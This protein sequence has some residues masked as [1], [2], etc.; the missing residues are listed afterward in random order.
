MG[1]KSQVVSQTS[2]A[3]NSRETNAKL[4][5]IARAIAALA[6]FVDD[7]E[8]QLRRIESNQR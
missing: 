8:N 1:S 3:L 4:D 6:D 2:A 7:I 5:N